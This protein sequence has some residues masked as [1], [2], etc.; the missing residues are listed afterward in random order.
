MDIYDFNINEGTILALVC[1]TSLVYVTL[2]PNG[3]S[4]EVIKLEGIT[5]MKYNRDL[6]LLFL[7]YNNKK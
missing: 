2:L 4:Q 5:A 1:T 3:Q 6:K 7:A